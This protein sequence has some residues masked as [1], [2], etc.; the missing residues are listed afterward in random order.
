MPGMKLRI[1]QAARLFGLAKATCEA[2]MNDL[3]R[4]G[5]L[6]RTP[7]GHYLQRG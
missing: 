2:V 4:G 6:T 1:E 5:L 3:V 7:D